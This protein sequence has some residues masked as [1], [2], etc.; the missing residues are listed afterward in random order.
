M[1]LTQGTRV[2]PYETV[3]SIGKGGIGEVYHAPTRR[4]LRHWLIV[5]E[6]L[7]AVAAVILLV[8]R[9]P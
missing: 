6:A 4:V 8:V 9:R 3:A 7:L 2:G 5:V 1:S